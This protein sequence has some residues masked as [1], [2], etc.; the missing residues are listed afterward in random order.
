MNEELLEI[1]KNAALLAGKILKNGFGTSFTIKSKE[2]RHNLVTEFDYLSENT[3]IEFIKKE[4]PDSVF[5][6]EESG[7]TQNSKSNQIRW[8]IDPL[9]GTVNFAHNIPI[10]SVSIACEINNSLKVGVVYQPL[11][12]ELFIASDG[13][14]AYLNNS[15]LHVTNT[16]EFDGSFLVTGFPY[17]QSMTNNKSAELF[18]NVVQRGIPIR[19]LGSAA[20][21]LAYIAAGRFDGFWEMDLNPW[22]VAAGV[23]LIREAGGKVTQYNMDDYSIYDKTILATNGLIHKES[24]DFLISKFS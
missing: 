12:D 16:N 5:L 1:A 11:L 9:D 7:L 14:G 2:G 4:I 6:A 24:S 23:L 19:R 22:D 18:I 17:K 3:I 13:G 8:I 10:F 20:L 21:D 15:K